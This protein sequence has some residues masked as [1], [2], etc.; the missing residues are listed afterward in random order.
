MHF[1]RQLNRQKFILSTIVPYPQ[2]LDKEKKLD[3]GVIFCY[4]KVNFGRNGVSFL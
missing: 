3:S 4:N 1:E 2:P